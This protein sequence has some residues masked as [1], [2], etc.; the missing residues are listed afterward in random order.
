MPLSG[1]QMAVLI[2]RHAVPL[3]LWVGRRSLAADDVVQEA[4]C[5]LAVSEPPPDEPVAWL[6]RVVRNLAETE[7]L[8]GE[9]RRRR[10][11]SVAITEA[12]RH[13]PSEP[14]IAEEVAKA[15]LALDDELREVVTAKIWGELTFDQIGVLCNVSTA[16]ASRRYRD[17]LV[18]LKK[19]MGVPCPTNRP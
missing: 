3:Q 15:V 17:A 2:A 12:I 1:E 7:R 14:L 8:A 19:I 6:Y 11:Q 13:D 10:E 18:Q 5:R 4:F 9:R 16:T